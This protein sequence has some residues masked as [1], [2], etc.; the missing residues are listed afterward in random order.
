[1]TAPGATETL[2]AGLAIPP[3]PLPLMA[4]PC[5]WRTPHSTTAETVAPQQRVHDAGAAWEMC[6]PKSSGLMSQ[7]EAELDW[8]VSLL[9][10]IAPEAR[11]E[12]AMCEI[13]A[14]LVSTEKRPVHPKTVRNWARKLNTPHFR[15]VMIVIGM[16]GAESI[17]AVFDPERPAQ[18]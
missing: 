2:R 16:A 1:M 11:S 18:R 5:T 7:E 4:A 15:C 8:F 3:A 6:S 13:V 12:A 14:D 17:F 10:K 9:W